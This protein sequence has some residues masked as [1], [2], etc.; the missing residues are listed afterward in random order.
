M[1][2]GQNQDLPHHQHRHAHIHVHTHCR[3]VSLGAVWYLCP[4]SQW[5][6]IIVPFESLY[7]L[8]IVFLPSQHPSSLWQSLSISFLFC[9]FT[10]RILYSRTWSENCNLEEET[11]TYNSTTRR[12]LMWIFG[13]ISSLSS[14]LRLFSIKMRV[15]VYTSYGLFIFPHN[16]VSIC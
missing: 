8:W 7:L 16:I 6:V 10:L 12:H 5:P 9:L 1:P 13:F 14:S 11:I 2:Q 4:C 3:S 15:M